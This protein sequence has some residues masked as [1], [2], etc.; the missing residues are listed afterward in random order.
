MLFIDFLHNRI[1]RK[2]VLVRNIT[3][4]ALAVG[5]CSV[6]LEGSLALVDTCN[7]RVDRRTAL[8]VNVVDH[9]RKLVEVGREEGTALYSRESR[10]DLCRNVGSL[11][12]ARGREGLVKKHEASA[13]FVKR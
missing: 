2:S 9:S 5:L 3:C 6:D 4:V 11:V 8:G 13:T 1:K 7:E 12:R 10:K